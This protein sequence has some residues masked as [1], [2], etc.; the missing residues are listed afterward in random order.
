GVAL[1]LDR[2]AVGEPG[3][4]ALS[5]GA[6][7]LDVDGVGRQALRAPA[8]GDLGGE[9]GAH[10]AVAVRDRQLEADRLAPLERRPAARD[11]LI[12]ERLREAVVL[13]LDA[14]PRDRGRYVRGVEDL[15]QVHALRLPVPGDVAHVQHVDAPDHVVDGAEAERCHDLAQLLGDEHHEVDHVLGLA[16]ELLPQHRVLGRDAD[17]AGVQVADAHHDAARGDQRGGGEA[18]LLGAQERRDGDVPPGLQLP[19]GLHPDAPAEI[20][21]DQDL[22]RLGEPELPGDARVLDRGERGGARAARVPADQDDVGL[23]LGDA[24]GDRAHAHLGNQ[25]HAHARAIVRVLE[26]VDQLR[27]VLDRVNVVVRRRGDEPHARRRVADLR[28]VL[29]DLVAGELAALAGLGALRHLDL[30]LVAV[31]EVVAGHAEAARGHLLDGAAAEVAVRVRLVA[32]RVLAALAGVR[33]AADPVHGDGEVLVRLAADRAERHGARL[34][35]LHDLGGGLDLI[36]RNGPR[37]RLEPEEPADGAQAPAL[38]VYRR[39]VLLEHLVAGGAH[40]V[41]EL[42]DRVRVVGVV[43]ATAAPLVLAADVEVAVERGRDH[44]GVLVAQPGLAR[45]H[46]EPDALDARRGPGEVALDHLGVEADGLEDLRAP[47]ALERRDAHLGHHLEDALVD[48]LHVVL[49]RGG[50]VH[51]L[52]DAL[53]YHVAQG[54]EGE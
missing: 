39:R 35:A 44:V 24:G 37:P 25:L 3:A 38:V 22:L 30:Q 11:D 9:H 1:N 17:R 15:R 52:Q 53:G 43:L 18:V 29:I 21:G 36:N 42:G 5:R 32:H 16:L 34:E 49:D 10:G 48:R 6:G 45:D 28:D 14:A 51:V 47:V 46:V 33:L 54:L 4:E 26:I 40:R 31:D 50:G 27:Q 8:A 7:E 41:L 20:V 19:V 13:Q 2:D 23:R 12:V